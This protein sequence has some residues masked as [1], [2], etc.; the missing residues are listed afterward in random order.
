[1][2]REDEEGRGQGEIRRGGEERAC[3]LS[4]SS[5]AA[6]TAIIHPDGASGVRVSV[7][8]EVVRT[9][10]KLADGVLYASARHGRFQ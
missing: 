10:S 4:R 7:C 5:L 6:L 9:S 3:R 8:G 2:P 1:M